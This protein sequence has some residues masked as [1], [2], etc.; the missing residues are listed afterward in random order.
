MLIP[1]NLVGTELANYTRLSSYRPTLADYRQAL[2][3]RWDCY[4][5]VVQSAGRV[6]SHVA[7]A[8]RRDSYTCEAAAEGWPC[9]GALCC[10]V[11]E[12]LD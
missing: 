8:S 5:M 12:Q 4:I 9:D 6:C 7:P 3:N 11:R 2:V 1:W 10:I